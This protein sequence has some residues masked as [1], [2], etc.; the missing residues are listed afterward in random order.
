MLL[1]WA[2]WSAH[3]QQKPAEY[4]EPGQAAELNQEALNGWHA[5]GLDK[6]HGV[7][8]DAELR[9]PPSSL[10]GVEPRRMHRDRTIEDMAGG[11][12]EQAG[13]S[14]SGMPTVTDQTIRRRAQGPAI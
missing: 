4:T 14:V 5:T 12:G 10:L 9:A 3:V 2:L 8:R 6:D 7:P 1:R 13:G 11:A